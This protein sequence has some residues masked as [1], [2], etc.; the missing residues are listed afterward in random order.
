MMII[1]IFLVLPICL[2]NCTNPNTK[3]KILSSK[4]N[5]DEKIIKIYNH[6][7]F[8]Y[9]ITKVGKNDINYF[10]PEYRA[11]IKL[12]NNEYFIFKT[13]FEEDLNKIQDS[14]Y[15]HPFLI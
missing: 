12:N 14:I 13:Y 2:S 11:S 3:T 1:F 8:E 4:S 7:Y 10:E 9:I 6:D 5:P 15:S